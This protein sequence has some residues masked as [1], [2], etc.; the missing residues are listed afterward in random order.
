MSLPFHLYKLV[1]AVLASVVFL[2]SSCIETEI[3]GT[4]SRL[5]E[6][7]TYTLNDTSLIY[8]FYNEKVDA[9]IVYVI[10]N[11][12]IRRAKVSLDFYSHEDADR[13]FHSFAYSSDVSNFSVEDNHINYNTNSYD[14]LTVIELI[15][16]LNNLYTYSEPTT[17]HVIKSIELGTTSTALKDGMKI[18]FIHKTENGRSFF[19]SVSSFI[20]SQTKESST[21]SITRE[22]WRLRLA[23][24]GK[25]WYLQMG[26]GMYL[27]RS[28][29]GFLPLALTACESRDE[30]TPWQMSEVVP[31]KG[32]WSFSAGIDNS[33]DY[34]GIS[35][36]D[37]T[38]ILTL[39]KIETFTILSRSSDLKLS[40][41]NGSLTQRM[42]WGSF[43]TLPY[44]TVTVDSATFLGWS[45]T[46]NSTDSLLL[47]G[48]VIEAEDTT[49]YAIFTPKDDL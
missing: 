22:P 43:Y 19:H 27:R 23:N 40:Y 20:G 21:Y 46:K 30:A 36:H 45:L 13:F 11:D 48:T 25:H 17:D 42:A 28:G 18:A 26:N 16:L 34:Y 49:Y 6:N 41:P 24:D 3:R 5:S 29:H 37:S 2:C 32:I 33:S 39:N 8:K 44:P 35:S 4:V 31:G 38:I 1:P 7:K 10:T 12:T 15:Q 14:G 9:T 47:P